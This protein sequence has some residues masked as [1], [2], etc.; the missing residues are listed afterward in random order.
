MGFSYQER[1]AGT[2]AGNY[3]LSGDEMMADAMK[4]AQEHPITWADI[5][6]EVRTRVAKKKRG[7]LQTIIYN[8]C[9]ESGVKAPSKTLTAAFQRILMQRVPGYLDSFE[10]AKSR[11][12]Q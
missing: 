6:S 10:I 5:E 7:R 9:D 2:L 8:V 3:R 4:W 1:L 12:D 11:C